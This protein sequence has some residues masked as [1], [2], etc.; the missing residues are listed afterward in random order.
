MLEEP[1][2]SA[3][4]QSSMDYVW[5]GRGSEKKSYFY[6]RRVHYYFSK[7]WGLEEIL[8]DMKKRLCMTLRV[9][10]EEYG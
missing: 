4:R 2:G 1:N 9:K 7:Y 8:Y 10:G 3:G 5:W 6:K